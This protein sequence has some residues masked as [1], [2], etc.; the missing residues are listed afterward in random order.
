MIETLSIETGS[1]GLYD[2]TD[3]IHNIARE[4]ELDEGLCTVFLRHTSASMIIQ[5]NAAPSAKRDLENWFNRLVPENDPEYT[6]TA[7][8]PDDMPSHIKAALTQTSISIPLVDGQLAF[9]TW[10][11]LFLWEHR[12]RGRR[13]KLVVHLRE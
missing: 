7:E 6:H 11:G 12:K 8:G 4:A 10:Q 3:Q 13:R 2:I 9:G 1:Q 5:E